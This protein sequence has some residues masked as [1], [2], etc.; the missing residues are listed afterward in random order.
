M[1]KKEYF[2]RN[3]KEMANSKKKPYACFECHETKLSAFLSNTEGGG[4]SRNSVHKS[5]L[6]LM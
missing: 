2:T 4:A 5:T 6:I 3:K 1:D